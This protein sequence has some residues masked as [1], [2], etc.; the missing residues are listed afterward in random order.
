MDKEKYQIIKRR[1]SSAFTLIEVM[2]VVV[3][4]SILA[5]LVA[6]KIMSRPDEARVMKA[7]QDIR[8]L[9]AAVKLYRLDNFTYPTTNQGLEALLSMPA[10]L[11]EGASWKAGGYIERLYKDPWG[12][13]YNYLS[14][15]AHGEVD[16]YSFGSDGATG[17]D[18]IARD[19]GNW[20]LE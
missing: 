4:L 12:R 5:V 15:G 17:G 11:P 19:I 7:K 2:A 16:I 1:T 14:P 20:D 3:I 9:E 10:D 18:G 6:P 13:P 8:A